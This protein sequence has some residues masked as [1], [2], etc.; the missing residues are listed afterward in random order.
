MEYTVTLPKRNRLII[1]LFNTI[2]A[3]KD[4]KKIN[5]KLLNKIIEKSFGE[6][7]PYKIKIEKNV[8]KKGKETKQDGQYIII[9]NETEKKYIFFSYEYPKQTRNGFIVSKIAI[10]FRKWYFDETTKN[11]HLE[12]CLLDIKEQYH[13]QLKQECQYPKIDIDTISNVDTINNYNTFAYKLCKTFEFKILNEDKLPYSQYRDTKKKGEY[14]YRKN[15][16]LAKDGFHNIAE[17]KKMRDLLNSKNSKNKSSYILEFDDSIVIYGK[18][19]GNNSFEM[20]LIACTIGKLAQEEG[21]KVYFYQVK[22]NL[23]RD[24]TENKD[25]K[26]ITKDNIKIMKAFNIEVFDELKDGENNPDIPLEEKKDSRN[27]LEFMKNLMNKFGSTDEKKCYLCDC[28]IQ[29][30]IIASHIQRV[31]DINKLSVPFAEKRKKAVDADNGLWLCANHDKLFEYGLIYFEGDKLVIS[32]KV[33]EQEKQFIEN[34]TYELKENSSNIISNNRLL[35]EE[36]NYGENNFYIK[37]KDYNEN[38][39]QYLEIHKERTKNS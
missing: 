36:E 22:D 34:I 6:V 38:M 32:D 11:K 28:A 25:A 27:Q 13:G 15:E 37:S 18:T 17:I 33:T 30:L 9:E 10:P 20:V 16:I 31:C 24:G 39:H 2:E 14:V 19:Y 12:I 26:P 4:S 8:N 7:K 21:K 35:E 3:D 23:G 5:K 29:K 1:K